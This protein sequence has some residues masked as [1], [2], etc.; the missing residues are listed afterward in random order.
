[1]PDI[2]TQNSDLENQNFDRDRLGLGTAVLCLPVSSLNGRKFLEN[3]KS[4]EANLQVCCRCNGLGLA[5]PT[6]RDRCEAVCLERAS[7]LRGSVGEGFNTTTLEKKEAAATCFLAASPRHG[8]DA[9]ST[10]YG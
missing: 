6:S 5:T 7:F 3:R 4:R 9:A 2:L 1:M 8:F 10:A